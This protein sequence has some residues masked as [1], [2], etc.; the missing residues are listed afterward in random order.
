MPSRVRHVGLLKRES[1]AALDGLVNWLSENIRWLRQQLKRRDRNEQ[2]VD[3][4]IQEAILR[5]AESCQRY[6]VRDSASVFVR[7][8]SRLSMNDTRN[9]GRHLYVSETVEEL[10][11]A[12]PLID[13]S[14]SAEELVISEQRW[15]LIDEVLGEVD[16]RA[17]QAFLANR[18]HGQTYE[19]IGRQLG[20]SVSTVEKDVTWVM[21]LLYD[22]AEQK[23]GAP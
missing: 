11:R 3:D 2:D 5:V 4:L 19:Q 14:P 8:L 23:W 16:E 6:E 17:R 12:L 1:P 7:T 22:A 9:R 13:S 20:V 18:I 15:A 21:A 10:A